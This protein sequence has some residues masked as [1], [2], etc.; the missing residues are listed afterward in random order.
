M[1]VVDKFNTNHMQEKNTTITRTTPLSNTISFIIYIF[2]LNLLTQC[3]QN[4]I[5]NVM[6]VTPAVVHYTG[7]MGSPIVTTG[8]VTST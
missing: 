4:K 2:V 6:F 7:P 3:S 8:Y 5:Q 1:K